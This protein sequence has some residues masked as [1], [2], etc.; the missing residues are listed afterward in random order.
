MDYLRTYSLGTLIRTSFAIGFRNWPTLFLIYAI[1]ALPLELM[2]LLL[3]AS[4]ETEWIGHAAVLLNYIVL[5]FTLFPATVAVSEICLGI[6]PDIFRSYRRAFAKPGRLLGT[7]LL[8]YLVSIGGFILLIIPG[9]IFSVWFAFT[10]AVVVL[11]GIGGRAALRRSRALARGHFFRIAGYL[12]TVLVLYF[13]IAFVIVFIMI[14]ILLLLS[15]YVELDMHLL[16]R[17][18]ETV[19][20]LSALAATPMFLAGIVLIYYDL[21]VRK[22]SYGAAQLADDLRF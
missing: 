1:L 15:L 4:P 5:T 19:G 14:V 10:P 16:E 18:G 6:R 20:A 21:K 3:S 11:E 8:Y 13:L 2:K 9:I 12:L 7:L 17:L 22:E